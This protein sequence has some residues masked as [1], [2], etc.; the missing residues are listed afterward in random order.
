MYFFAHG[1][2]VRH[3][4]AIFFGVLIQLYM[5]GFETLHNVLLTSVAYALMALVDRQKQH[6]YVMIWAF[7]YLSFN[8]LETLFL[9]G[10]SYEMGITLYLMLQVLKL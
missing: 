7:A 1:T 5:F 8:H 10:E 4:Y 3:L 6:K 2:L 9:K